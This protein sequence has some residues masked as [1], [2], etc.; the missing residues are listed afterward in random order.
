MGSTGLL[1]AEQTIFYSV[2][3]KEKCVPACNLGKQSETHLWITWA[4]L[5]PFVTLQI[6]FPN[7]N[8]DTFDLK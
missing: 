7:A 3:P 4:I 2:F 5:S 8:S 1:S 6:F